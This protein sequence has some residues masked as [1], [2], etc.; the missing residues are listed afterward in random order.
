MIDAARSSRILQNE[1]TCEVEEELNRQKKDLK[2]V[3]IDKTNG[4]SQVG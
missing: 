4:G 1:D 3:I 2:R